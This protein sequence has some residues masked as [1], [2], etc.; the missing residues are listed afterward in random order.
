MN[1]HYGPYVDMLTEEVS[2]ETLAKYVGIIKAKSLKLT[3]LEQFKKLASLTY[4]GLGYKAELKSTGVSDVMSKPVNTIKNWRSYLEGEERTQGEA[5]ETAITNYINASGGKAT[6]VNTTGLDLMIGSAKIEVKSNA[7]N[8]INTM[9]QTSFYADDPQKF[10]F[11]VA[12]TKKEDIDVYVVSS[13]LLYRLSLIIYALGSKTPEEMQTLLRNEIKSGIQSMNFEEQILS[14]I[15]TGKPSKEY[16]KSF[17]IGDNLNV[18]FLIYLE[19]K[20]K[21]I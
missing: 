17:S 1:K 21:V 19:P 20:S 5:V 9:L 12:N 6:H 7:G 8:S 4:H 14:S 15:M 2:Y 13:Q 11:F 3:K 16:K 10:Y 18:R